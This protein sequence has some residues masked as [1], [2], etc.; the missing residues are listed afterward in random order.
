M[1]LALLLLA[2][3]ADTAGA[4]TFTVDTTSDVNLPACSPAPGDCS[5]RGALNRA[6]GTAVEHLV[7]FNI[8]MTDGGCVAATGVCTIA[9]ATALPDINPNAAGLV[10]IDGLTQPGAVANAQSPDQGGINAQL[11]IVLSGTAC[12][13]ASGCSTGLQ[14]VR[15]GTVRGLVINGFRTNSGSGTAVAFADIGGGGV[16]E[17][18]YIGTDVSGT[19]A[20]PNNFGVIAGGNPS[21]GFFSSNVRVGGSLPAQ[22]NVISGQT[23]EGIN[24]GGPNFRI[25][26]NLIG[27]NAAGTAAVGNGT[28]IRLLGGVGWFQILGGADV[29]NRNV[30]SGNGRGVVIAGAGPTNGTRVIGNFIGT[31]VTGTLP[32]GNGTV[33]IQLSAGVN[34]VQP[35]LVGG[36]LAGEGNV[37]AF[38]GTQGVATRNTQ[39]QV[40]GNRIFGNGQLGISG[41]TGDNGTAA[42]RLPNDPGDPDNPVNNGQNFPEISAYAV[43]GGNVNLS[44]RVDSTTANSAYPLRVE[45]F[46]ADGDEGRDLIGF[47]SYLAA[48]AQ[49]VK[50]ISLPIPSGLT[51]GADDVILATATD[52]QGNTSEFSF[53]LVAL[54][55]NDSPDPHPAGLPFM[56]DV[57][58]LATTGPF[59]P[60]GVVDVSMNSTP[61]ATCTIALEPRVPAL[62]SGGSCVLIAPQAGARTITATYRTFRGAFG[63]AT[64]GDV[65]TTTPHTATAPGPEQVGFTRCRQRVVEGE[66]AQVRVTRNSGGVVAVGASLAH[67]AGTATAGVDYTVPPNQVL[68]WAAGDFAPKLINIPIAA[69]APIEAIERFRL[70]LSDPVS[71]AILPFAQLDIEIM[72]GVDDVRFGDSFE[73]PDCLP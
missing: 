46:K 43:S 41:R 21:G 53:G 66:V 64:G 67:S 34:G 5:L 17:G 33:G 49:T 8:P 14:F 11:K 42:G 58:A 62:T 36:T 38:N 52:A 13:G 28:G 15:H 60:N 18:C 51:L 40:L 22:R 37:I 63:S 20:V 39:G 45:F 56:V 65:V 4:A 59:K 19:I 3:L 72:D 44:Y 50:A 57:E 9:P 10:S 48:E 54:A 6:N 70:T 24:A 31:D 1:R 7:H 68:S 25:L 27:T 12:G 23:S 35:P 47:D 2:L 61:P 30:I 55:V 32:L 16:V 29:A 26:G 71:T 73:P 69:D